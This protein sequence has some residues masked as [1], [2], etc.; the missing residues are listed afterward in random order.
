M[1]SPNQYKFVLLS[2]GKRVQAF[3]QVDGD[4][5]I[6]EY[7]GG[8]SSSV[9]ATQDQDEFTATFIVQ[10]VYVDGVLQTSGFT[11]AGT[12]T[13]TFTVGLNAGQVVTLKNT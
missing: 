2:D 1:A 11:G 4:G 12:I 8:L 13:I 3:A 9:S 6:I 10:S 5:N 7:N